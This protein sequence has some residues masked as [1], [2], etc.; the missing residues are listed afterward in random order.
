MAA[1][2]RKSSSHSSLYNRLV[3]VAVAFGSMTYGYCSAIIGS[4]I[5]QP[6]WY[7]F[8]DLPQQG[9]PGYGGKTTDAIAT[10]NGLYSAGGAVG[11]LFIM[12]SATAIGRKHS[13]Q[14][15]AILAII[16]GAFQGGAAALAMFHV[17]RVISGLGIGIL[18]TACPMYLSELAPPENRGWLVGHH[19]IFLVFGYMLSAWLG[20]ACYFATSRNESFAWRFPL[21]IQTLPPLVLLITSIWIPRSPRWLLQK[22][23]IDEAWSVIQALRRSPDDPDDL[24]AK[25]ELYQTKAQLALDAAKLKAVGYGPWMACLKKKSYRKRLIIG[26]LTQ[27]GAEFAGP[28]VINN[29]SVIIYTNLGQTG[30]MPLLLSAVWLT[31]AGV[32]YNPGGAW[33]HDKVNSRRLMYMIGI[34]GCLVTTSILCALIAT[35]GGTTSKAGNSGAITMVFLYLALQ[36]TFCDTTMY[37]YVSEIF[38]T[39]I[40][41]I[42]MGFSLFGQFA[43][44]IILLQTAPIGINDVGWK[45]YLVIVAWCIVY[46]PMIYFFWPETARLSLEEISKQFGDDVAVHVNDVSEDQRR[47]LDEFLR[48][49]DV[50]HSLPEEDVAVAGRLGSVGGGDG[51]GGPGGAGGER[52]EVMEKGSKEA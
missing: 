46:L 7:E 17:G 11:S 41:P 21:C 49:K 14:V 27:W 34:T 22:G 39:E 4:T 24:A 33:L 12:W 8:F 18:V 28:L 5:G 9:E 30:S 19:A 10:A 47:E 43:A 48:R 3:T 20:Y 36:G 52:M 50:V 35:Y 42:G 25:E 51:E 2:K 37:L 44:T 31:T 45:Y 29:Y 13:I 15:G 26:F 23:K 16:G 32:I 6:G 38:P 1:G 40:R